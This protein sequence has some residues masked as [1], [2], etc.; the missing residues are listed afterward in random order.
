MKIETERLYLR[1]FDM[2]KDLKAYADIMGEDEVGKWLPKGTGYTLEE[3][4]R[5]MRYIMAHWDK[6]NYGIWA[7]VDKERDSLLGHCGLNYVKELSEVEVLYAFGKEAR[8][9]GYATE[10]GRASLQYAFEEVGLNTIIGLTKQANL[11]S[12]RVLE[13]IGL[14]YIKDIEIFNFNAR[15]FKI[16]KEEYE[17]FKGKIYLGLCKLK[18]KK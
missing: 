13:K 8:G 2:E 1:Y 11:A 16:S 14:K 10:A 4:E 18:M 6:Y 3:T 17:S 12:M 15:Y 5:F 7:V 9:K